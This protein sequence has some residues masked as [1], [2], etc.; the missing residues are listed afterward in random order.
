VDGAH[1]AIAI[2]R[3]NSATITNQVAIAADS[4]SGL[5]TSV[6]DAVLERERAIVQRRPAR[7]ELTT[8]PRE[9]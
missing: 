7:T 3:K 4:R 2:L 5:R 8:W 9:R 1:N 6:V